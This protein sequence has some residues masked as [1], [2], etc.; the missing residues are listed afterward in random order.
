MKLNLHDLL[1]IKTSLYFIS[2]SILLSDL[3][4]EL[5]ICINLVL[6]YQ[7]PVYNN[8]EDIIKCFFLPQFS[9]QEPVWRLIDT[10]RAHKM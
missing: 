10:V 1:V 3:Q 2:T 7:K 9:F 6:S 8:S 5:R 4:L